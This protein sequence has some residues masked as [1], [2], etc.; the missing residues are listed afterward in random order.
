MNAL[1]HPCGYGGTG[2]VRRGSDRFFLARSGGSGAVRAS[3]ELHAH[4][5]REL[6]QSHRGIYDQG[7]QSRDDGEE[8]GGKHRFHLVPIVATRVAVTTE[9]AETLKKDIDLIGE[10]LKRLKK[11]SRR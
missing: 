1:G 9:S 6:A 5:A 10:W 8:D 11:E 4:L 3:L 7:K 2:R